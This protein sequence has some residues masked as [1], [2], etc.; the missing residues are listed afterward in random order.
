MH[1]AFQVLGIAPDADERAIKRAY[2]A[3]LKTS[4]PDDDPEGFQRLNEAYRDALRWIEYRDQAWNEDEDWDEDESDRDDS[5]EA[6]DEAGSATTEPDEPPIFRARMPGPELVAMPGFTASFSPSA[7][8]APAPTAAP[9]W[10]DTPEDR[11]RAAPEN[12][13]D[14]VDFDALLDDALRAAFDKDPQRIRQWLH[15]QPLLWSLRHKTRVGHRFLHSLGQRLPPM[16]GHNFDTIADFFGYY[17]LHSGYDA[18]RLR[19]L[20]R[21]LD[22]IW[23]EERIRLASPAAA[24]VV[25]PS[26]PA[27]WSA[28]ASRRRAAEQ[29]ARREERERKGLEE[30]ERKRQQTILRAHP[31]LTRQRRRIRDYWHARAPYYGQ[32]LRAFLDEKGYGGPDA[33]APNIQSDA[34]DF[35]LRASDDH[36]WSWPRIKLALARSLIWAFIFAPIVWVIASLEHDGDYPLLRTAHYFFGAT[37]VLLGLWFVV[38]CAKSILIW[39]GSADPPRRWRRWAHRAFPVALSVASMVSSIPDG[40]IIWSL[41]LGLIACFVS[42]IRFRM[43]RNLAL[44]RDNAGRLPKD[45]F[46]FFLFCVILLPFFLLTEPIAAGTLFAMW[47]ASLGV[48][49]LDLLNHRDLEQGHAR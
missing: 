22:E 18:M 3:K 2:A 26:A 10:D 31:E 19:E 37:T 11:T 36:V 28:E 8:P 14:H 29:A 48:F 9:E 46:V 34:L 47:A 7:S 1:W 21:Q 17:D 6:S 15:E 13:A 20:R 33:I 41:Y 40:F 12:K 44:D 25:E 43:R 35:W 5:D 4:R 42:F 38:A 45:S 32:Q 16:P 24:M 49:A 23:E 27:P 30:L 39:Q